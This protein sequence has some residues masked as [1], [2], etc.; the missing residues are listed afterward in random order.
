M[1]DLKPGRL[2]AV[3]L[4]EM[5]SALLSGATAA[6]QLPAQLRE[7]ADW[8]E[9]KG[10]DIPDAEKKKGQPKKATAVREVYEYW[11]E[12]TGRSA[13]RYKLTAERRSKIE[14]RLR[15]FSI[16]DVKKAIDYVAQ[17]EFHRGDND[18]NQR[19]DDITTICVNDTRMEGYRNLQETDETPGLYRSKNEEQGNLIRLD[20]AGRLRKQA[21]EALKKGDMNA[22]NESNQQLSRLRN[23]GGRGA[24]HAEES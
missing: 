23:N 7:L 18:R 14:A 13:T 6:R 11:L 1:A 20:E 12:A 10:Q 2:V 8:I 5:L 24:L 17:S 22:Y 9:S 21:Q 15:G 4:S 16:E 19:Y 3:R